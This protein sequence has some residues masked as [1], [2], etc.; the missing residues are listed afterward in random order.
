MS[1]TLSSLYP[2]HFEVMATRHDRALNA[3]DFDHL[4]IYGG[5]QHMIFLD[6]M[7]YPFK[8]NPHFKSWLPILENPNC[9]LIYTPGKKPR[10]LYYQPVDFWHKSAADPAGF[11]TDFFDIT[12]IASPEEAKKHVP[13]TE[14]TAWIGERDALIDALAVENLNPQVLVD[15]LHFDRAWK[16]AY[17]IECMRRANA[18]G[19]RAHRVAERAFRSGASEY[20]IHLEYMR[21]CD[22]NEHQLPYGNIIAL[23]E[24]AAVLHYQHQERDTPAEVHSFLIDAGASFHGYASD[25]TRTYSRSSDEFQELIDAMDRVQLELCAEVRPGLDY[26]AFHMLAH[27]KIGSILRDF[28]FI[29][30]DAEVAV[31]SSLTGTFFPH[32]LGH[33][34]GLQ[35]HDV[36]GFMASKQG[37]TIPRPEG[38]P[39]LRLTR[40]VQP[41][42]VF[43]VEP[44]LYFIDSLLADLRKSEH[45]NH[46]NWDRV[47]AFRKYGGVRIE[48]DLVVTET[49]AEN[50][51]RDQFAALPAD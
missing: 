36:G 7:P 49:G 45:A 41:T 6:D 33:Y 16:T 3:A 29:T 46:V 48:D 15:S 14:R 13:S 23:N 31:E 35:V 28:D 9:F 20:E 4:V 12:M 25:I 24:N 32:G 47:D 19:S 18:L 2:E 5:S 21:A 10:L 22:H 51:T 26:R 8:V 40:E 1:E 39:T 50:L 11:W 17:E 42:Q 30:V 43:T 34:I 44:G 27:R 37:D 38:Q